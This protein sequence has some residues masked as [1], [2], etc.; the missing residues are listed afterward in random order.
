MLGVGGFVLNDNN[1]LLVIQEKYLTSLKRP[2]WKIPG[3]MADPGNLNNIH[4]H[5]HA[6]AIKIQLQVK[7]L[8][9]LLCVKSRR[10]QE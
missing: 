7:I 8:L 5:V 10:K 9:R 6:Y 2:I 3:G 1:D 4:V